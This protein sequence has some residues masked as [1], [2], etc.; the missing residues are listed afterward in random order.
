MLTL[1][2]PL[3]YAGDRIDKVL[4]ELHPDLSRSQWQRL[5]R[6]KEVAISGQPVRANYKV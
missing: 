1:K 3:E 4:R 5:V 2:V 6:E